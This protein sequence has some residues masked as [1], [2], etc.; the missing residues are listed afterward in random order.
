MSNS[1]LR[2]ALSGFWT[3]F[4]RDLGDIEALFEGCESLTSQAYLD[5]LSEVLDRSLNSA[6]AVRKK[7]YAIFRF[8]SRDV[9]RE[10]APT[11]WKVRH[12]G[13][14]RRARYLGDALLKPDALWDERQNYDVSDTHV[15]FFAD[16]RNYFKK[17][18]KSREEVPV[19]G[20]II[21]ADALQACAGDQIRLNDS[22][23]ATVVYAN[24]G[25]LGLDPA[26]KLPDQLQAV[27]W[28]VVGSEESYTGKLS[29]GAGVVGYSDV[30]ETWGVDVLE[31]DLTLYNNFGYVFD[32]L[33]Y[34]PKGPVAST[35]AYRDFLI[36]ITRCL[37]MGPA[38][39]RLESALSAIAGLPLVRFDDET[40]TSV[41][42]GEVIT[43]RR[44]YVIPS[45]VPLKS[46]L[47][48][49][50]ALARY[51]ALTDAVKIVDASVDPYW[52]Y[53]KTLPQEF[54]P[55]HS[56]EGRTM[57]ADIGQNAFGTGNSFGAPGL[58]V[59][60]NATQK[61][62]YTTMAALLKTAFI[63]IRLHTSIGNDE[64]VRRIR[65]FVQELRPAHR[66]PYVWVE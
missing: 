59:G 18:I 11:T 37:S 23:T 41:S 65:S 31:D 8:T 42:P 64:T 52:W 17:A 66:Y 54:F 10:G 7:E 28:S 45:G 49:G 44:K 55:T 46:Y 2:G 63:G 15:R 40:V 5:L 60:A 56:A 53:G 14:W 32:G 24:M 38:V 16:P 39:S 47:A 48:P 3:Q 6:T 36:G 34:A 22:V 35:E 30:Y 27:T 25:D 1:A 29:S 13:S 12:S 9:V 43:S 21:T 51:Q 4:F 57:T 20:V 58:K 33:G 61:A 50:V 26:T 19:S 62:P